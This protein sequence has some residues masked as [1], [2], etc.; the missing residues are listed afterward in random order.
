MRM[1]KQVGIAG[2]ALLVMAAGACRST[3]PAAAYANPVDAC[4][5]ITDL[6]D[7]ERCMKNVVADV[8]AAAKR[9]AER[10]PPR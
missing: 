1:M 9:E 4:A 7:R 6:E 5:A 8:A 10:R 3:D 2:A